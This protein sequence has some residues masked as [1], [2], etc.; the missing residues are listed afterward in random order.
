MSAPGGLEKLLA[1]A[2]KPTD[3]RIFSDEPEV[4]DLDAL[5]GAAAEVDVTLA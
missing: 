4:L 5:R 3:E 1:A 2:D